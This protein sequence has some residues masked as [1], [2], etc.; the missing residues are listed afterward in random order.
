M[1]NVYS[2]IRFSSLKQKSGTSIDRQV[3]FAT[4]WAAEHGMQLDESL[5]MRDEGLSAYHGRHVK[6]GALGAFLAAIEAGKIPAGSVLIVEGLDRLSRA[7]PLLAQAQLTQIIN[8][9]IT[10]VTAAD[11]KQYNREHLKSNP[12]DLVYSLLVMIRAHEE[13]E[14]KSKR[15]KAALRKQC[16]A[17]VSEGRLRGGRHGRHPQ[18]L[19]ADGDGWLMRPE[20][21]EAIRC[22]LDLFRRGYGHVR[23]TEVL[24]ERG[25]QMTDAAP[26]SAQIYRIVRNPA[27]KGTRVV[28]LDGERYAMDGYYPA[29]VTADE[30]DA[31]QHEMDQRAATGGA[32]IKGIPGVVTGIGIAHCGYC[33]SPMVAMNVTSRAR[34]DG[35]LSDGNRRIVCSSRSNATPCPHPNGTSVAPIERAIMRFCA[36]QMNLSGVLAGDDSA[37]SQRAQLE[38]ARQKARGIEAQL[39]R[40]TQA[41]MAAEPSASP[42]FFL[43]KAQELEADLTAAKKA[44]SSAERELAATTQS[45]EPAKAEAWQALASGVDSLDADARILARQLV[46]ETF[47]RLTVFASGFTP[48][49]DDGLVGLVLVGRG[50]NSRILTVDRKTGAWV[51]ERRS[52]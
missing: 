49:K 31:L 23:I 2:Y 17:W 20:R 16:E 29:I 27:I 12:M 44:V 47:Q 35:S 41:L 3:D 48:G 11:G 10:V 38:S 43:R 50:G 45:P 18:W 5:S 13:S 9:D 26:N 28:T 40:L 34:P 15:A 30:F 6:R 51:A 7:E 39:E 19:A 4:Q 32:S 42:A 37:A 1:A 36:D 46:R 25:M 52:G 21:V 14:T 22:A 24:I 33:G 8:A